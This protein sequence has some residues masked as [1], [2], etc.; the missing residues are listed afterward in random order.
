MDVAANN[1]K[2][3][4]Q[5]AQAIALSQGEFKLILVRCNYEPL[6]DRWS[7]K[8][9]Q[10]CQEIHQFTLYQYR[11]R[12]TSQHLLQD[13]EQIRQTYPQ[14]DQGGLQLL[15]LNQL[16]DIPGFLATTNQVRDRLR[17]VCPFP[18]ALWLNDT[19]FTQMFHVANDLESWATSKQFYAE[20]QDLQNLLTTLTQTFFQK[21]PQASDEQ[22]LG[23]EPLL[24][25][26]QQQDLDLAQ[27]ELNALGKSLAPDLQADLALLRSHQAL[28]EDDLDQAEMALEQGLEQGGKVWQTGRSQRLSWGAFQRGI[29]SLWRQEQAQQKQDQHRPLSPLTTIPALSP[30]AIR[31][32]QQEFDCSVQ[33][34]REAQ[35]SDSNS[36]LGDLADIVEQRAVVGLL[37]ALALSLQTSPPAPVSEQIAALVTVNR[38][39]RGLAGFPFPRL[40]LQGLVHLHQLYFQD[41]RDY[42]H[43]FQTR[44]QIQQVERYAGTRSFIGASRL[45]EIFQPCRRLDE[46]SPE[47]GR[48]GRGDDIRLLLQR[49]HDRQHKIIVIH[50]ESGVGK[51]SLVNAGLL[52][53]L[54]QHIFDGGRQGMPI[55]L[56]VYESWRSQLQ[57]ALSQ[58]ALSQDALTARKTPLDAIKAQLLALHQHHHQVILIFDQFEEF[59]LTHPSP[60]EQRAFF[61]FIGHLCSDVVNLGALKVVFSLR[62]PDLTGLLPCNELE[63]MQCIGQNILD[64]EM[65]Y[66][67]GNFSPQRTLAILTQLAPHFSPELRSQLVAD[68]SQETEEVRPIELQIVGFQLESEQRWTLPHYKALGD[69]PKQT[70]ISRYLD[71]IVGDCGPEQQDLANAILLLLTDERGTRPLR[72]EADLLQ[73][74]EDI[75]Q[76]QPT[77]GGTLSSPLSLAEALGLVLEIFTGSGLVLEIPGEPPRFQ[78]V[79]DYL[80]EFIQASRQSDLLAALEEERRQRL[81]AEQT[82]EA[83]KQQQTQVKR[84]TRW[85]S[86]VGGLV[87]AVSLGVSTWATGEFRTAKFFTRLERQSRMASGQF[88]RHQQLE[89]LLTA[90]ANARELQQFV[91]SSS[92]YP[93]VQPIYRL[94]QILRDIN[95]RNSFEGHSDSVTTARFTPNGRQVLSASS[96]ETV[97]LWDMQTGEL[98]QS[99]EGH[100]AQVNNVQF[101]DDGRQVVSASSDETVKLWDVQTGE[102]LQSFEGHSGRVNNVQFSGDG[103]QVVSASWDGTVKLWDVQT[104]ELLQSLEYVGN[105]QFSRD[106]RQV[107]SLLHYRIVLYRNDAASSHRIEKV[108]V[109]L[110][111]VQTGELLNSFEDDFGEDIFALLSPDGRQVVLASADGTM[112]LWDV[113]TGELLHAFDGHSSPVKTA[114]FSKD[115]RQVLS[116]S[117]D[118]TMKLWDVQTGELL[119]AFDGHSNWVNSVQFS[120]DGHQ[121]VSASSDGTVKLW[122]V[123]TGELLQSLEGHS[124]RIDSVQ[125]SPDGR[126]VVLTSGNRTVKLWDVV[127]TGELLHAFD[128]HSNRI[129]SVQFSPDGRQVVSASLDGTLKLWDVQMGELLHSFEGHSGSVDSVQFSPDGRQV[130]SASWD[131]TMKLWDVQMGELLHSFE[132]HSGPVIN[133]RFSGDGRQVVSASWDE[134]MKLWDVQTGELL[135]SFEGHSGSVDSVQFSP[136][137]RQILSTSDDETLKLWDV[138]TGELLHSFDGH[139]GSVN[140]VQFSGD[141]R[142]VVSASSDGTV[143]LWDVQTGELLHSFEGHSYWVINARFSGDGRQVVSASSDGT[144]KLWGVQTG[145]LFHSFEG[146]SG[147]VINAQVSP[148][149]RQILSTSLDGTV[150]L[151]DVQTGELLHSFE[152]HSSPVMTAQFSN[153]GRQVLS[154]SRDGTV[155]VWRVNS[156]DEQI[157]L[158]CDWLRPYLTHNPNVTDQDRAVCNLPPRPPS[159]D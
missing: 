139:S 122:D 12:P 26:Q 140:S 70:L 98:L 32:P 53:L 44:Q 15:G 148:D 57:D 94:N 76:L 135:H 150:K 48:S 56:R 36:N 111:D 18:I 126:Q 38:R 89:A 51:S 3:L 92:T 52:P 5:L 159:P 20:S 73:A 65:L 116:A 151:W 30:E 109:K 153:D 125:F 9:T 86:A 91:G 81:A 59:F 77:A 119:H 108:I 85:L 62:T 99:L 58:D 96:D 105:P 24:S 100:S 79:H 82:L 42:L 83:L 155:K 97:N 25:P 27:Q 114:Q 95:F 146:H 133:A 132:G 103:R 34:L 134:T 110:W 131:E 49:L 130:V 106:G 41:T 31:V 55:L 40:W 71:D 60:Q 8:L 19:S 16:R 124:N 17:H 66:K 61:D 149:G 21:L 39:L 93:T 102:L 113:Q 123:Q 43:A 84:R 147:P 69:C 104:G 129:D 118:R 87:M 67:L 46:L 35:P 45:E 28:Q 88:E 11:L 143:K 68:L 29:V 138:Q 72:R 120:E 74:L 63:S 64:K 136:D 7:Q 1:E 80:A 37:A 47:I 158:A 50:G 90:T 128:S 4:H 13:I 14:L 78:L 137:G 152:G 33:L 75:P 54:R 115:G 157:D 6:C 112:K 10:T 117:E 127:Q 107:S 141:G 121:V 154:A 22:W 2:T 23:M 144:V 156:L 101:S 145:E 142:Q